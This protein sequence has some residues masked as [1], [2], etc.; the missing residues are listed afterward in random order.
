MIGKVLRNI[1]SFP[2]KRRLA[3]LLLKEKI[4]SAKDITVTGEY[5]C[6]FFLPNIKEDI[7]FEIFINGIYEKDTVEFIIKNLPANKILLD[8]G[9][10]IGAI[11]IPVCKKRNDIIAVCIEA[12]PWIFEY[13][14]TNTANNSI[15]NI[16]LINKAI[17][18]ESG[19]D[20]LFYSPLE[21][22]G[23]GSLS[24]I[25]TKKSIH[26]QTINLDNILKEY[27]VNDIGLIK[28]DVEGFEYLAFEGGKN[29]LIN[30]NAPDI[31]F[32]FIDW[33]ENSSSGIPGDAQNILK[34]FGYTIFLFEKGI[35]KE[36]VKKTI[37]KGEIMLFATKKN[38]SS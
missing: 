15:K 25:F 14:K 10:N 26:V 3:R 7:G 17:S 35:V 32:E 6:N 8:I 13:L 23:K 36:E 21:Q 2:G 27:E 33:A 31:L 1:P 16:K 28:I 4:R 30:K 34:Q 29:L 9:A 37:T 22:F 24:P 20:V 12:A 11:S 5:K 18:N 38:I 19:V